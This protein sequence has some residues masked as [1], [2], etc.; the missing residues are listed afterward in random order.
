MYKVQV[1]PKNYNSW[2]EYKDFLLKTY[3]D[4]DKK[5]I[6]E[7]RFAKHLNNEYVARQQCKQLVLNDY[8]NNF[9]IKN[10][11]NPIIEKINYWKEIL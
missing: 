9:P 5:P 8:E 7:K 10:T 4:E 1:L 2:R 11:E 3:P 6:F